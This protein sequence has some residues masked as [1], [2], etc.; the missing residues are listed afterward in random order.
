[1]FPKGLRLPTY[2]RGRAASHESSRFLP[3]S[4]TGTEVSTELKW[5]KRSTSESGLSYSERGTAEGESA[6]LWHP[7]DTG[8]SSVFI[9]QG[10]FHG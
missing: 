6:G 2:R 8:R 7:R 5:K 10:L 1:M 9:E 3:H 4:G